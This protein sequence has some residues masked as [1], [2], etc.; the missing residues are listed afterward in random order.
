LE[1]KEKLKYLPEKPGVYLLKNKEGE[2]LYVGKALSLKKRV[3]SYFQREIFSPRLELLVSHVADVEWVITDSEA[4]AF[5]LECNLIKHYRPRY[6]IRLRDD[7]SYPYIKLTVFDPFPQVFLTRNPGED[8]SRYFGPYANVKA[9]KRT[10][11][12]IG[13]LF[14][15]RRCKGKLKK[16]TMPCL[17]Y[18]IKECS[19]PCVGKITPKEYSL[20][21]KNTSLFLEGH[22]ETLLSQLKKEM[23]KVS[24]EERFERAAKLR[25]SITAIRRISQTQKVSSFTGGD[26]DLIALARND[27]EACVLVFIVR[28][29][30]LIDKK[31]F[32]LKVSE[33][34]KK[35][36]IIT[37]FV[38]QYYA[39]TSF[40]PE[41]VILERS[42]E[43]FFSIRNW[44]SEK[45]R[46]QIILKVPRRGEKLKFL[47]LA[48]KNARMILNQQ[49]SRN[50][51]KAL[52]ELKRYL[53]LKEKPFHIEGFDISN[54]RGK[55]ATGSVVVFQEGRAKKEDYRR[56]R[57]KMVKG[58]N[59]FAMLSEVV[60]RRYKR[61]IKEEKNLPHLILIDGGK[62]Q[63][64]SCAKVLGELNL[65]RIPLVG[66]AKEFEDVYLYPHSHPVNI[67]EDSSGLKL[68]EEIRD[69]AHRF[70]H[71]HHR[72][73]RDKEIKVSSLDE[74]PGLGEKTKKLLLT[75]FG[76]VSSIKKGKIEELE[77]IPGIGKKTAEKILKYLK[78]NSS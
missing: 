20:L 48:K 74:I 45:K 65:S 13:H 61:I 27:E 12:L 72:L 7:K 56:F 42:I 53:H 58:I 16:R 5:L 36:E 17:N 26:K 30:K 21:V 22:Y 28:E 10:L 41:E 49:E 3:Q 59:D 75:H 35:E 2:V 57:I 39:E 51:E 77:K 23:Q 4:E 55:Q 71:A 63:L 33:E 24:Q 70:A 37:S 78:L 8:G 73:I 47:Q 60:A 32:L 40:I 66:L 43:E 14:P 1:L 18:H 34:N 9:A 6:N 64:S 76:S 69:E 15:L 62:G 52:E 25:D 50:K 29:G 38:K 54:I 67:P 11:L 46:K 19:A 44:L 31:H 68:L